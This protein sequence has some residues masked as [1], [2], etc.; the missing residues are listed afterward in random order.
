MPGQ[1]PELVAEFTVQASSEEEKQAQAGAVREAAGATGLAREAGPETTELAGGRREVIEA[2]SGT[3]EAALDAGAR[4]VQ[5]KIEAPQE[6][7]PG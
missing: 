4:V 6:S 2:L 7:R 1:P 5:V 3:I